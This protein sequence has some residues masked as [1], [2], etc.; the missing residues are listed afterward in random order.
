M[1]SDDS[2]EN[3]LTEVPLIFEVPCVYW[4]SRENNISIHTSNRLSEYHKGYPVPVF[5]SI[6][7]STILAEWS[8]VISSDNH[9]IYI[10]TEA[11]VVN[12]SLFFTS[13][14]K[15][16]RFS[17]SAYTVSVFLFI[18]MMNKLLISGVLNSWKSICRCDNQPLTVNELFGLEM[19]R[20]RRGIWRSAR[21]PL[22]YPFIFQTRLGILKCLLLI[23]ACTM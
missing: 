14:V 22:S 4:S 12:H 21:I 18:F 13:C 7:L 1:L 17:S 19:E 23:I 6:W 8:S 15:A 20:E 10:Y 16:S 11:L 2:Y 9:T 3:V 5:L